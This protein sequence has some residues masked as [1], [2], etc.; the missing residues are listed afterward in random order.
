[1]SRRL[2]PGK[3]DAL[4]IR[5]QPGG[6]GLIARVV[7]AQA[8]FLFRIHEANAA[9]IGPGRHANRRRQIVEFDNRTGNDGGAEKIAMAA[10][11]KN[12]PTPPPIRPPTAAD[13]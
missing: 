10:N 2:P 3:H 1:M 6:E 7:F 11:W 4:V 13:R 12:N 5:V 8:V 9:G